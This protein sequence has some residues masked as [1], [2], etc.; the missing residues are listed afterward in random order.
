MKTRFGID[1]SRQYSKTIQD[2][3]QPDIA[4]SMGCKGGS[5]YIGR[6]FD[7]DW[8]LENPTNQSEE[9]YREVISKIQEYLKLF[10]KN[11]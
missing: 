9:V 1:M 4:I 8:E 5:P 10:L 11:E 2:I 3:P 7:E 6:G